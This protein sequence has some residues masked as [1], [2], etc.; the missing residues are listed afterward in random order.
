[1]EV[2][3][4]S[5]VALAPVPGLA[6]APGPGLAL[7]LGWAGHKLS[8]RV[9]PPM[10]RLNLKSPVS[11]SYRPP[12]NYFGI[13]D[14]VFFYISPSLPSKTSIQFRLHVGT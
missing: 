14:F 12:R 11:A 1:V 8:P 2:E 5:V 4:E 3:L 13:P 9:M 7:E 6:L 10:S